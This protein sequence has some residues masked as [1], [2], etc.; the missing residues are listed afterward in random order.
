MG[1]K[2]IIFLTKKHTVPGIKESIQDIPD[3][4]RHRTLHP[5]YPKVKIYYKVDKD[6]DKKKQKILI[7][8]L[9]DALLCVSKIVHV[10]CEIKTW[11][12][13]LFPCRSYA[14]PPASF[15]SQ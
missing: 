11:V 9:F 8:P 10:E 2:V 15:K 1:R 3:R 12:D 14:L 7:Q 4:S 5:Q 6:I 13:F